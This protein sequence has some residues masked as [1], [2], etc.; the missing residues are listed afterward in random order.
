VVKYDP[1]DPWR[2]TEDLAT[3]ALIVALAL[4]VPMAAALAAF[5]FW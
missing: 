3:I 5:L 1:D 4:G 2:P